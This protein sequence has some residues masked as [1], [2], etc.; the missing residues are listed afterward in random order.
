MFGDWLLGNTSLEGIYLNRGD[1]T[2]RFLFFVVPEYIPSGCSNGWKCQRVRLYKGT[3]T[4]Y[5]DSN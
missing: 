1:T 3:H 2:S 5:N 4:Y